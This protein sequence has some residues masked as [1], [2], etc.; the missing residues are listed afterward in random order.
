MAL[1]K[2]YIDVNNSFV[3]HGNSVYRRTGFS[4]YSNV[5]YPTI[6]MCGTSCRADGSQDRPEFLRTDHLPAFFE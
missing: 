6:I 3:T 5:I 4:H 1:Q 2:S